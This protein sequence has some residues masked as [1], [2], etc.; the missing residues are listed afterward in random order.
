MEHT[1]DNDDGVFGEQCV[2][3]RGAGEVLDVGHV[4]GYEWWLK[5]RVVEVAERGEVESLS[6]KRAG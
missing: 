2:K 6:S 1:V 4:C 3:L 5:F